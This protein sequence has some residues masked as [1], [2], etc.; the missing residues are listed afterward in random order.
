MTADEMVRRCLEILESEDGPILKPTVREV[1]QYGCCPG[2]ER[3]PK[4]RVYLTPSPSP[5]PSPSPF[6]RLFNPGP[7]AMFGWLEKDEYP[8]EEVL[9][10][11]APDD[12]G[13]E[14]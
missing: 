3:P 9:A 10:E 11:D 4:P 12:W 7:P 5:L 6:F 8:P 14:W 1:Q 13:G 2:Y